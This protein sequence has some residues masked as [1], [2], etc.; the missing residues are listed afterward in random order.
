VAECLLILGV[1]TS[2]SQYTVKFFRLLTKRICL[3]QVKLTLSALPRY[4][5]PVTHVREV[6]ADS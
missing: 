6:S 1:T 3:S 5:K 2:S 4:G